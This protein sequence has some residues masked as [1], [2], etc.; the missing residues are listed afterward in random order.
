MIKQT[1]TYVDQN[2]V[3][4]TEDRYFN[5]NP[6]GFDY[7]D[8]IVLY[9]RKY[10]TGHTFVKGA[11]KMTRQPF[12]PIVFSTF[13]H[14]SENFVA[15]DERVGH[16]VLEYRDEGIFAKCKFNDT[17]L[18]RM[19]KI[20]VAGEG[21]YDIS[22]FANKVEEENGIIKSGL[23]TGVILCMKEHMPSLIEEE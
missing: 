1:T 21:I 15:P 23:I 17:E 20:W 12:V 5:M 18:G 22:F 9:D 13:N 3:T 16:A 6:S 4:K 19:A 2:G 14:L 8:Y 11:F 10:N 7:A